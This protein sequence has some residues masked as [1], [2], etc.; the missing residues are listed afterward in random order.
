LV[1][2]GAAL[3]VL[4]LVFTFWLPRRRLWA[5]LKGEEVCIVEQGGTD[6]DLRRELGPLLR[7]AGVSL[8]QEVE[9]DD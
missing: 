8:R 5:R 1:W 2:A 7:R 9:E 3:L 6:M 4:S